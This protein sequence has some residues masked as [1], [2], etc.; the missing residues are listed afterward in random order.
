MKKEKNEILFKIN[1][2]QTLLRFI[3]VYE[4]AVRID[5]MFLSDY[6]KRMKLQFD[7]F[8][9]ALRKQQALEYQKSVSSNVLNFWRNKI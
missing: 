3:C 2:K 7:L 4:N 8:Q 5:N 6:N 1:I 9:F